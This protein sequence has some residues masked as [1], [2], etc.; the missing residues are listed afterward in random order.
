MKIYEGDPNQ[1][2]SQEIINRMKY[3]QLFRSYPEKAEYEH[4]L[5][6]TRMETSRRQEKR[7]TQNNVEKI[8]RE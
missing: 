2:Q 5:A 1:N 7:K 3:R 4:H 8:G 6:S